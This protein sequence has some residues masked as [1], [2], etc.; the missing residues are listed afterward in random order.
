MARYSN[1]HEGIIYPVAEEHDEVTAIEYLPAAK[2][3]QGVMRRA[4]RAGIQRTRRK[5]GG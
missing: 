1:D 4:K 2:D 3:C 5:A